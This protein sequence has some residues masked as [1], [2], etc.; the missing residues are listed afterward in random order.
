MRRDQDEK[1]LETKYKGAKNEAKREVAKAKEE[2]TKEWYDNMESKEGERCIY[3]L[4]R[5]RAQTRQDI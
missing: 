1:E 2:A 4:A 3:R 5:Q